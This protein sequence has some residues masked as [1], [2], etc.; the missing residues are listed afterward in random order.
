M[1]V[2]PNVDVCSKTL[3]HQ[4]IVWKTQKKTTTYLKPK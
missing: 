4:K 3:N 2:N 1:K